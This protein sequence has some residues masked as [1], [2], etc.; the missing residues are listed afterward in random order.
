MMPGERGI[1]EAMLAYGGPLSR[2]EYIG[3]AWN[4]EPS[5]DLGAKCEADL[6]DFLQGAE[7]HQVFDYETALAATTR[8]QR[9]LTA[10][11][12]NPFRLR[13]SSSP[14]RSG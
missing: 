10:L 11:S 1:I 7:D 5:E 12:R 4:D 8:P 14:A 13:G 9:R 2:K 3:V 6:P